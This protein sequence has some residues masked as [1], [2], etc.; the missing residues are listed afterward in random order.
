MPKYFP[1]VTFGLIY[2]DIYTQQDVLIDGDKDWVGVLPF[3][4]PRRP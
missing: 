4:S 1:M 3:P 2:G